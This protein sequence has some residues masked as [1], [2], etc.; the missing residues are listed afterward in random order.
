MPKPKQEINEQPKVKSLYNNVEQV[1]I[2]LD[3]SLILQLA[4]Q[5]HTQNVTLNQHINNIL[6]DSLAEIDQESAHLLK[7]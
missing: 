4:L 3:D 2:D 6:R 1:D 7:G 5:A